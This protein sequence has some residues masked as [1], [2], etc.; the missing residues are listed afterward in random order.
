MASAMGMTLTGST[1][2]FDVGEGGGGGGGGGE[3]TCTICRS[4]LHVNGR[5]GL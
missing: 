2:Q 3:K 1:Q 5:K 4:N